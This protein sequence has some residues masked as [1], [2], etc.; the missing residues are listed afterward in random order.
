MNVNYPYPTKE[1]IIQFDIFF[2]TC[3][4]LTMIIGV[5]LGLGI[6]QYE[7]YGGDTQKRSLGNRFASWGLITNMVSFTTIQGFVGLLR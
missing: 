2:W 3:T 6:V 1:E 4:V 5:P 7:W